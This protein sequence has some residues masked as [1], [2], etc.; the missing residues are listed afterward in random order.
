MPLPSEFKH[1]RIPLDVLYPAHLNDVRFDFKPQFWGR[2][3]FTHDTYMHSYG[4]VHHLTHTIG[5]V[6]EDWDG[7]MPD[8]FDEQMHFKFKRN[9]IFWFVFAVIWVG[10]FFGYATVGLKTP[11]TNNPFYWRK[12]YASAGAIH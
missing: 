8:P 6:D 12:K 5:H 11:Q 1:K 7:E 10:L 9:P 3:H 2:R 4:D